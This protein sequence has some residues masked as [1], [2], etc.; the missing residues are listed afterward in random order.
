MDDLVVCV[1]W[2]GLV[3][4]D[5]VR[6]WDDVGGGC[7]VCVWCFCDFVCFCWSCVWF[8]LDKWVGGVGVDV[9]VILFGWF[10]LVLFWFSDGVLEC[11]CY[12]FWWWGVIGD[13]SGVGV[14]DVWVWLGCVWVFGG[15]WC[16]VVCY[17]GG[18]VVCLI[19]R[20]WCDCN[21]VWWI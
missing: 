7:G 16:C 21:F 18:G 17:F 5:C 13:W 9:C 2:F 8:C 19:V 4:C 6:W 15:G 11:L 20:Y 12:D 10:W 3:V 14:V 1:C